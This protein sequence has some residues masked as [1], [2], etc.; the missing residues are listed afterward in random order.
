MDDKKSGFSIYLLNEIMLKVAE[1]ILPYNCRT[2]IGAK[3][4]PKYGEHSWWAGPRCLHRICYLHK[5]CKNF[6]ESLFEKKKQHQ[7]WHKKTDT[8]T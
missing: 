5:K 2:R 6:K 8:K 3:N 4:F 7:N 1:I